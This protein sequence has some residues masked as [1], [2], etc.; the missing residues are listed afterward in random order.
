MSRYPRYFLMVSALDF[1]AALRKE[2]IV[3]WTARVSTDLTGHSLDEVLPSLIAAGAPMFGRDTNGPDFSDRPIVPMGH[4]E[5][6]TA[7]LKR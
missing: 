6:G 7:V 4:V 5:V 2:Y 1:K 3:L